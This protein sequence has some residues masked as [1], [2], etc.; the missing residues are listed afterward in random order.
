MEGYAAVFEQETTLFDIAG[1]IRVREEIARDAF[2]NVLGRL[3]AGD[4]LVHLNFGHDMKTAVASATDRRT[5]SAASSSRRRLPR[6]PVLRPRRP[7][8]P[9][10]AARSP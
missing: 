2:L 10:R 7:E 4:G 1:W 6:A 8:R 9:G 5:G 3:A